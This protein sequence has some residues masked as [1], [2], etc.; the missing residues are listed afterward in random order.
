MKMMTQAAYACRFSFF[1][2]E[3]GYHERLLARWQS[4]PPH[5]SSYICRVLDAHLR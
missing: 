2:H 1:R 4:Y 5:R 3:T